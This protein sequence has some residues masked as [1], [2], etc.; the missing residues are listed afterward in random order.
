MAVN[1]ANEHGSF[2]VGVR[3]Q[4]S[5][6][7]VSGVADQLRPRAASEFLVDP[8]AMRFDGADARGAKA[9]HFGVGMAEG[10]QTKDLLLLR[11]E[12]ERGY[13]RPVPTS[14]L[15]SERRLQVGRAGGE[16]PYRVQEVSRCCR[17]QQIAIGAR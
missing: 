6:A 14:E 12:S 16:G 13:P 7:G 5:E 9:R 1:S 8:R 10:H 11:G 4:L 3:R 15:D 17:L 2:V